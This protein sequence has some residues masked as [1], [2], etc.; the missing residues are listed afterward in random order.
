MKIEILETYEELSK[1]AAELILNYV[2]TNPSLNLALPTGGTPL[3]T[4]SEL[5]KLFSQGKADFSKANIFQIDEYVGLPPEH[6]QSYVHYLTKEIISPLKIPKENITFYNALTDNPQEE[7]SD[8]EQ[9]LK[10]IGYPDLMGL[11]IGHNSHI[12]FN[13]PGTS[14]TS[15]THIVDL[16]EKT[17]EANSR[18]FNNKD[19]VP[20]QAFTTGLATIMD[21]KNILLLAS[22]EGKAEAVAKSFQGEVSEEHPA[23]ILQKHPSTTIL[24]DKEAASKLK[25]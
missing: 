3:A 18:F 4:Y 22:G 8:Y 1:R 20:K 16:A 10:S 13:E 9:T 12:A 15:R 17:I 2:N 19:E 21:S 7:T 11:G 14:F 24:L 23:S 6:P 5:R 25:L